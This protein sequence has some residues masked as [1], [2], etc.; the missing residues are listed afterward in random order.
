MKL[1]NIIV[2]T[3]F[4]VECQNEEEIQKVFDCINNNR[5]R[6]VVVTQKGNLFLSKESIKEYLEN[7]CGTFNITCV[8]HN[9]F[10]HVTPMLLIPKL[11][12]TMSANEFLADNVPFKPKVGDTVFY[13]MY[14]GGA[15]IT[16]SLL[17][18]HYD[19]YKIHAASNLIDITDDYD[20][21]VFD[22]K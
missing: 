2:G 7:Q 19:R 3:S 10:L 15:K 17:L 12:Y 13:T 22:R 21:F 1:K 4:C 18:R 11:D 20:K 5:R 14:W 9:P 16:F 6:A 8:Q